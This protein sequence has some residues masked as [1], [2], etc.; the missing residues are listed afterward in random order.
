MSEPL[1]ITQKQYDYLESREGAWIL[2]CWSFAHQQGH[3][4]AG[5]TEC[6]NT[7]YEADIY[8]ARVP[9]DQKIIDYK[10]EFLAPAC[11]ICP[12][13]AQAIAAIPNA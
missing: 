1:Q 13:M 5:G 10:N 9:N 4:R 11:R 6:F 2:I 12:I 3:I 8:P 7:R